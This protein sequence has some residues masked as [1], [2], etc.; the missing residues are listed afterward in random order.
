MVLS[1]RGG[2]MYLTRNGIRVT[3]PALRSIF[4]RVP[5][6][7]S[8]A[9]WQRQM[10]GELGALTLAPHVFATRDTE[11]PL[12]AAAARRLTPS[13]QHLS[14]ALDMA[15]YPEQGANRPGS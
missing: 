3:P 4:T 6:L 14:A 5:S 11:F 12:I 13:A 7:F 1:I 10:R 2:F 9:Y 8:V 15:G